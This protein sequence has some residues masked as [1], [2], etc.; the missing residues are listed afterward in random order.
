MITDLLNIYTIQMSG[1][2]KERL[3]NRLNA[4]DEKV[5]KSPTW[6]KLQKITSEVKGVSAEELATFEDFWEKIRKTSYQAFDYINLNHGSINSM[7]IPVMLA[8][9]EYTRLANELPGY[10][11]FEGFSESRELLRK[12]LAQLVGVDSEELSL[13]RNTSSAMETAIFGMPLKR[14]EEVILSRQDYPTLVNAWK[15]REKFEGIKLVWVDV[16]LPSESVDE[17]I[18]PYLNAISAKTRAIQVMEM[19]NWNGQLI[20]VK[21]IAEK[22]NATGIRLFVDGAHIPGQ[23][24]CNVEQNSCDYWAASLH[25]WISA[26]I[27]TG[28]LT[29]KKNLISETRPMLAASDPESKDIRKFENFG[30]HNSPIDLAIHTA[31]DFLELIGLEKKCERLFYLKNYALNKLSEIN[32]VEIK[33]SFRREFSCALG[34]FSLRGMPSSVLGEKLFEQ[35]GIYTVA[36]VWGGLDGVRI[37]PNISNSKGEID[38]LVEAVKRLAT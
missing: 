31:L 33:T 3:S 35:H 9:N 25:K 7:P 16:P 5:K 18:S 13:Q 36:P 12:R 32:G 10:W 38:K 27:G 23:M 15:Q 17:L 24:D 34:M 8:Q 37:S 22:L 29:V 11:F 21:N 1:N 2:T 30:I 20:P 28:L 4:V 19:F 6:Q 26:P 14:G